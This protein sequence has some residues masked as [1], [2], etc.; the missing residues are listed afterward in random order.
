MYLLRISLWT[1]TKT[2]QSIF[3]KLQFSLLYLSALMDIGKW[4]MH[5]YNEKYL[6]KC[7]SRKT[8]QYELWFPLPDLA[9]LHFLTSRKRI[10][11]SMLDG[12][13]NWFDLVPQTPLLIFC[14]I[15]L[16]QYLW[17]LALSSNSRKLTY[18]LY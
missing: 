6:I 11:T 17:E 1:K 12:L 10:C 18:K 4:L 7:Y 16:L 15:H 14:Q 9:L 3:F 5:R 8:T 13:Q 2:Q